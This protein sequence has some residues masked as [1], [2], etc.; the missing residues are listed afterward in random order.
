MTDQT[1][2]IVRAS[3]DG[4]QY[5]EAWMARRALGLL[6][7]RDHLR[8]IAAEGLSKEDE[9]G[10]SD[11]AIEVADATFYYGSAGSF[12]EA[13][14]VEVAQFKYSI[15]RESVPFR[16]SDA[17]KTLQKFVAAEADF[18]AKDGEAAT[19]AK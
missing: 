8:A 3:R 19:R 6:L 1:I 18:T 10:F 2:D 17:K 15:A 14:S 5:H 7:P 11:A 12:K 16:F 9:T 4:H 13:L